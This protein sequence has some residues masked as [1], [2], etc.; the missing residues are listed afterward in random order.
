MRLPGTLK[1]LYEQ[2]A[3]SPAPVARVTVPT[4]Y[5]PFVL[6]FSGAWTEQTARAAPAKVAKVAE[7]QPEPPDEKT[8]GRPKI[9]DTRMLSRTPP[10]FVYEDAA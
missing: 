9:R 10:P 8:E 3:A 5:G 2:L 4:K 7:K 6:E 1:A